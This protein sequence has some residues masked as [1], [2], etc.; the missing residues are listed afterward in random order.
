MSFESS[1]TS[2]SL[3]AIVL[4]PLSCFHIKPKERLRV[5]STLNDKQEQTYQ[6]FGKLVNMQPKELEDWLDTDESKSVGHHRDG[7]DESVGHQ[8][9]RKIIQIKQT[10]KANLTDD[11]IA[12]MNKTCNYINRHT[13]Q[14]PDGDIAAT[15]WC[16]S[17][18]NWGHDPTK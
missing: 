18:K 12:H 3:T 7:E 9:G 10:K 17:L 1:L 8:S 14:R 6:E 15:D 13:A 16:Y 4:A 11:Q 5:T 2:D